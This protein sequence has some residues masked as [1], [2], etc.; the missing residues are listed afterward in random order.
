[1]SLSTVNH[2]VGKLISVLENEASSLSGVADEIR[3]MKLLLR[4]MRS[5]LVDADRAGASSQRLK[6]WVN[7]VRDLAFEV[8]DII[9]KFTYHVNKN[10][11]WSG[12]NF[13][14]LFQRSVH[15]PGDL[16]VRH[17]VAVKLQDINRRMKTI[18]ERNHLFVIQQLEERGSTP[19]YDP[20][21]R[22]RLSEASLFFEEDDIVGIK[23][24]QHQLLGWLMDEQPRRTVISVV[25]MGGSGKSTLVANT[26]NKQSVKQR[27]DFCTWVTI[28]QQYAI[29]E[30]FRSMVKEIYKQTNE[31][32]PMKVGTMSYRVLVETLVQ[33]LQSK[34]YLIV[35]DDVWSIRFWQEIS[36]AFPEGMH[37]SRI[38][39]TTRREDV[40][41]SP[42]G[43]VSY[44]HRIQPLKEDDAW[45]LFCKRAFPNELSGCPSHLDSLARNLVEKCEGLPLAIVTLG[46]LMSTKKSLA[47]WKSV[48]DNLNW[49]LSNN[50]ALE[51]VKT[52]LLLSYHALP[53]QLKQCFLYCCMFPEDYWIYRKRLIRLWM[54]EGFLEQVKDVPPET[55]A[56]S[57]LMDLINRSLL[58]V[59]H[60]NLFGRSRVL[61]MHDLVREFAL[62]ISKEEKL[63]AVSDGKK[64]VEENGI[65]RYSIEVKGKEMS[66]GKGTS[67]LCSLIIFVVDEISK[68]SFNTLPSGLKL[69]R[70]LDLEK[71]PIIELPSEFG[72]LFNLRYLNLSKTQVKILPK[73]IGKILNL[74]TLV[75]K[76]AKIKKLPDEIMKLQNLRHL[77][78]SYL[79]NP[80][81]DD[82]LEFFECVSVPPNV[83]K[84]KS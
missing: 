66:P 53:F 10:R 21:W 37:G 74:Q 79:G 45:N 9:D 4:S 51:S 6:D 62:S 78:A 57:Y 49:E 36:I 32:V 19:N 55:V 82:G 50:A 52:I 47:D 67:Q 33:Y 65:R 40:A 73:T 48:H 31:E 68:S 12:H 54:A 5:F 34:R 41:P 14:S 64:G 18:A 39:V 80:E 44:I 56:E 17:K 2:I 35:L 43:F 16:F 60:R 27:F 42:C 38:I 59:M 20:D 13:R 3:E 23:K 8:E 77:I 25:G 11:Q 83:F 81:I 75:L 29:E 7:D 24:P 84:I 58:Q 69:L 72:N 30:L 63:V 70:V 1:M 26:F 61:K 15:F 76:K 28:S 71:A 22:K 46:G